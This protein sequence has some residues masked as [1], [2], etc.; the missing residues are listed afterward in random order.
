[1]I[2][3]LHFFLSGLLQPLLDSLAD[4]P[5]WYGVKAMQANWIGDCNGCYYHFLLKV[6]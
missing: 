3:S 2:F 6:T 1:M 5:D 4:L